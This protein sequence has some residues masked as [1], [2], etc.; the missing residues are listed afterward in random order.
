[1]V[2]DNSRPMPSTFKSRGPPN[3][4]AASGYASHIVSAVL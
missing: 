3:A 4:A 1:M 2:E